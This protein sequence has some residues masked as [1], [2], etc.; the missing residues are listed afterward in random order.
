MPVSPVIILKPHLEL[1][2]SVV[3]QGATVLIREDLFIAEKVYALYLSNLPFKTDLMLLFVNE[4]ETGTVFL[5]R[6]DYLGPALLW[7]GVKDIGR[8]VSLS[9]FVSVCFMRCV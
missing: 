6:C 4:L 8:D 9:K 5:N 7:V 2:C 1:N 3:K